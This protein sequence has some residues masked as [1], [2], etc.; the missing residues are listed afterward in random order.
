MYDRPVC[1]TTLPTRACNLRCHYCKIVKPFPKLKYEEMK[2]AYLKVHM[3]YDLTLWCILGGDVTTFGRERLVDLTTFFERNGVFYAYVSNSLLLD[4]EWAD[5]LMEAGLSNWTVSLDSLGA[6]KDPDR[7]EK[8]QG[9][10]KAIDLFK[11]RGLEDIH[12][13]VTLDRQNFRQAPAMVQWLSQND[14]WAEITPIHYAKN[15]HYDFASRPEEMPEYV[16]RPED[17][18]DIENVMRVLV[19]MKDNGYLVHNMDAYLLAWPEYVIDL[20]WQCSNMWNM[21]IDSDGALRPC[22]H[23]HGNKTREI[24]AAE[25]DVITHDTI[26]DAFRQDQQDQCEGCLWNCQWETEY[27]WQE[28]ESLEMIRLYFEHGTKAVEAAMRLHEEQRLKGL[29]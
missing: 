1:V 5:D 13:T 17:A 3:K 26:M 8:A 7:N 28:T 24:N 6:I 23:L 10:L 22:L 4:D 25:I 14:I 20:S 21:T 29:G 9:A 16:F 2:D 19:D 15:E 18:K 11:A 12:C 27:I